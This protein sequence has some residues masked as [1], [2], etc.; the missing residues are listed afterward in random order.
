MNKIKIY[1][2]DDFH[3][4]KE[5]YTWQKKQLSKIK[6]QLVFIEMLP[7]E[8]KY[9]KL[10]KDL[11]GKLISVDEFKV[12]TDWENTWGTFEGYKELFEYLQDNHIS[13]YP[14]DQPLN[15]R[16]S[17]VDI[18]LRIIKKLKSKAN[19]CDLVDESRIV[20]F[21]KREAIF[22][23][24]ILDVV[25]REKVEQVAVIVGRN[26]IERLNSFFDFLD[27]Y[28][29]RFRLFPASK[30]SELYPKFRELHLVYAKKRK[31]LKMKNPPLVPINVL[32][33]SLMS[34][35]KNDKNN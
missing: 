9:I 19:I 18:E 35:L 28:E 8:K 16:N 26:H 22:S 10:C 12:K 6:P 3:G 23:K 24:N 20:L 11:S 5:S 15:E 13:I 31:I 2:I 21:M 14:M 4:L 30:R 27:E 33:F 1:F 29:A 7:C 34:D 25:G 17:L 32:R